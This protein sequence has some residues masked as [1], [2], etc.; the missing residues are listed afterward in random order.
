MCRPGGRPSGQAAGAC[1]VVRCWLLSAGVRR[2]LSAVQLPKLPRIVGD[3]FVVEVLQCRQLQWWLVTAVRDFH[4]GSHRLPK[5]GIMHKNI[6]SIGDLVEVANGDWSADQLAGLSAYTVANWLVADRD[7]D[8]SIDVKFR[9]ID[10][11]DTAHPGQEPGTV[12]LH[13]RGEIADR[14]VKWTVRVCLDG[15]SDFKLYAGDVVLGS[16]KD[17]EAG[18]PVFP[19]RLAALAGAFAA[20]DSGS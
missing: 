3:V 2:L 10:A 7:D 18:V 17:I 1:P 12:L 20:A 8:V 11:V 16:S 14:P 6:S 9:G 15:S 4:Q 19:T 13:L 5:E